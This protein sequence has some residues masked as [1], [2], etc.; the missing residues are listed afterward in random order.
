MANFTLSPNMSLPIPTVGVDPGPDY[1]ENQ[2][3]AMLILDGH[4]HSAGNGVQ[5]T[6][7]GLNITGDFTQNNNNLIDAKSLRF[8]TQASALVGAS[9]LGCLY[10]TG[11][12]LYYNDGSGNQVRITQSGGVAGTPGSISGLTS[13][14]SASY[15][16]GTFVF[17]SAANTAANLDGASVILRN[18]TANSKGLTLNPPAAMGSN[19]SITLP[20][21]PASTSAMNIDSSG[22]VGTISY[23]AIGVAM[24]ATGANAIAATMTATGANA[25][26]TTMT[27]TGANS[28]F[29]N[30]T[31]SVGTSVGVR[32]VA[33][34]NS[35][36]TISTT[37]SSYVDMTNQSVTLTTSGKPVVVSLCATDG[38]TSKVGFTSDK[39]G[40]SITIQFLRDSNTIG[41]HEIVH[42]NSNQTDTNVIFNFVPPGCC[43]TLD[44]QAASTYTYK[45]QWKVTTGTATAQAFNVK[46]LAYEL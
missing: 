15:N 41:V 18:T 44:A 4:D 1:A 12:D 17:Q 8:F 6:Q 27:S 30:Y 5:I 24:T 28:I 19:Y 39:L 38:G 46:L 11:A 13:P 9:D 45:A 36:G 2:N 32:G 3:S 14:A 23:D 31:R 20:T 10:R 22:N 29:N 37:S 40:G 42:A 34:S 16:A 7:S 21:L 35:S 43:Q 26:G 33:I 25:I